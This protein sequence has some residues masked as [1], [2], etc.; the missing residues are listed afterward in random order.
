MRI[1]VPRE[2]FP[3]ERRVALVPASIAPLKKAGLEIVVESGAGADAGFPDAAYKDKGATIAATR[4]EVFAADVVL[5]VRVGDAGLMRPGQIVIG[6]ADPLS[7]P[8]TARTL[9]AGGVTAFALELIPRI[10]RAQSMDVLSSMAT[11]GGYKAVLLAAN[12]LPRMFPLL[13]T[14]AGTVTPARVFIVGVG[15]AGLQAIATARK[16]GAVVEA[17]DVRPAV[18]EQVQSVGAKF[19][20]LPLE[21]AQ[22]EDKGGYAR[23]QDESFYQRQR[24][25]MAR[26]VAANDVVITTAVVPGKRAPVLV[27]AE[28]V[29]AMAPGSVVVD[30]AAERGGNCELTRAD[31]VVVE[32]GVTVL[33][34]TNLPSAVPYHASQRYAKNITT[35]LLHLVKDGTVRIDTTDEI[36][37]DTLVAHGG[38]VVN[39]RVRAALGLPELAA[40]TT[41]D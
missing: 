29:R 9:A 21:T 13:T 40:S 38:E 36:T 4:G 31:E 35:F 33:G 39:P 16:L 41:G 28:M 17:Y 20:E 1:G 25:M 18:K 26:V 37:R 22:A 23:A 14:A 34:P 27:T 7:S 24:E 32:N 15:V 10:T 2:Q 8:E 12:T 30:L 11:I 6:M 19:V 3:G 5:Q